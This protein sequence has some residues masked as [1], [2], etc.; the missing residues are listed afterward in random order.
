MAGETKAPPTMSSI[1]EESSLEE[2]MVLIAASKAA[3]KTREVI[4]LQKLQRKIKARIAAADTEEKE[5]ATVASSPVCPVCQSVIRPPTPAVSAPPALTSAAPA[6]PPAS[7]R[8]PSSQQKRDASITKEVN[9]WLQEENKGRGGEEGGDTALFVASAQVDE[10]TKHVHVMFNATDASSISSCFEPVHIDMNFGQEML[11]ASTSDVRL[12]ES[13]IDFTTRMT[14]YC[15]ASEKSKTASE[16]L[17]FSSKMVL[18]LILSEMSEELE[19]SEGDSSHENENESNEDS[20]EDSNNSGSD[21]DY[22]FYDSDDSE[23]EDFELK[24]KSKESFQAGKKSPLRQSSYV[25]GND[26]A[27]LEARSQMMYRFSTLIGVTMSEAAVLLRYSRF[28]FLQAIALW[29]ENSTEFM[30]QAGVS[31]L[32]KQTTYNLGCGHEFCAECWA[33]YV[34]HHIR[35]TP[36]TAMDAQCMELT[37]NVFVD[38]NFFRKYLCDDVEIQLY[39]KAIVQNFV[40][41]QNGVRWCPRPDCGMAILFT[42]RKLTVRCGN[43]HVFCFQCGE[44]PHAPCECKK[45]I[46]FLETRDKKHSPEGKLNQ[47]MAEN[48]KSCPNPECGI[49]SEKVDGCMY[50]RC[51]KCTCSWC[52][53]CGDY[54]LGRTGR[55]AP[56]HVHQCNDPTNETWTNSTANLFDNDG[57]FLWYMERY[58]NHLDSLLLAK[59]QRTIIVEKASFLEKNGVEISMEFLTAAVQLIVEC[60]RL[61][62]WSYACAFFIKKDLVR[63]RFQFQQNYLEE[64]TEKLHGLVEDI[65]KKNVDKNTPIS[66]TQKASVFNLTSALA[67]YKV[68]M[69]VPEEEDEE[70]GEGEGEDEGGLGAEGEQKK[71]AAPKV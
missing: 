42:K 4:K 27:V 69:E 58:D 43:N 46:M 3:R 36:S 60:R 53:Q 8:I 35:A 59:K 10:E 5:E 49:L 26:Q 65:V 57:R 14:E 30:Q 48:I 62:A 2:I 44:K 64:T 38:E 29:R 47:K 21:S 9:F 54:G 23:Q 71:A 50:L 17:T 12:D 66:A 31:K 32:K 19:E 55:P 33:D 18:K 34:K 20:N 6:A 68:S 39:E 56:H 41:D 61:L 37:C 63:E 15:F 25:T 52:W 13:G 67:K 70:E 24:F 45:S 16:V 7:L 22:S 28:N 40:D 1:S 51:P 11:G